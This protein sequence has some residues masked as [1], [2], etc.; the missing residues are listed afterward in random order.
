MDGLLVEAREH[1]ERRALEDEQRAHIEAL[2]VPRYELPRIADGVDLGVLY[3]LA[4][5]L[6]EQGMA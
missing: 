1:A 4:A 5:D 6:C 3:E 2:D